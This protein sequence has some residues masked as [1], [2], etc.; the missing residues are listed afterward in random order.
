MCYSIIVDCYVCRTA[1]T[2]I[3]NNYNDFIRY[4]IILWFHYTY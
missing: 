4:V 3:D 2:Y 1:Y